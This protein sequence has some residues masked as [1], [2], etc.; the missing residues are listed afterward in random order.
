[1]MDKMEKPQQADVVITPSDILKEEQQETARE[2]AEVMRLAQEMGRRLANETHG[3]LYD[4]VRFLNEL[5]H[6]TRIKADAIQERLQYRGP[7]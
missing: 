4:D 5:L 2:L 7:R 3:E 6:Q 1:M